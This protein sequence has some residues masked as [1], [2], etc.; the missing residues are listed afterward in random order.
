VARRR[1]TAPVDSGPS[2]EDL[3]YGRLAVL[4]MLHTEDPEEF[5]ALNKAHDHREPYADSA[6]EAEA[7]EFAER[8]RH[9]W[10]HW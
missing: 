7:R 4:Y 6:L 2:A 8:H 10:K 9:I 3:Q 5:A 1:K